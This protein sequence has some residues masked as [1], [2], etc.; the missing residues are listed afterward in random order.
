M[1]KTAPI[2]QVKH[3]QTTFSTPHGTTK[4]VDNIS[5]EVYPGETVAIV[6]ESGSGKSVTALS[7]MRLL[8]TPPAKIAAGEAIFQS[9]KLGQVDL[10]ALPEKQMQQVRG[11]EISMIFQEPMSSLNPVFTCGKQ[12]AEVLLLHKNVSR[13]E[14]KERT[15]ALFE[16]AKLPNPEKIYAAYP[17]QISGGQKQRVMIAMAMACKPSL[18]MA[19]EPTTALDVTVQARILQLMDELRVKE[20]T[21]V[22]FISHDF[23]VVAEVADRV[24]VMYKGKIVEQGKVLDIFTNPQHPYT[25]GLLACRPKMSFKPQYILPTVSDFMEE[26]AFGNIIKQT[27]EVREPLLVG[28]VSNHEN[29]VT[30]LKQQQEKRLQPPLLQVEN[31]KVYFPLRKGFFSRTID[32]TKAVDGV[33]FEI[34]TGE[35]VALVGESGCGKTTLGRV[36]IRLIEPTEGNI[37]FEGRDLTKLQ[38][39][40]LRKSRRDFQIVFQD[41]YA[42]LNPMHTI[43]EAVMEPMHVHKLYASTKERRGKAMELL[44]K[45]GLLPEHFDR[46]PHEFSGGQRQ[47]ISIARALALQPKFIICDEAVSSLDVSVQAQVL[48]LLNQLKQEFQMTYLFITHDLSV[49]RYMADSIL[50]MN[51]GQIVESDTPD[52]IFQNPQQEYTRTLISAIPK[53]EPAD[54]MAAQERRQAMRVN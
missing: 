37:L 54:I 5:F 25:K 29:M 3:L 20:N 22:L 18:L 47:R 45:V 34:K 11:N 4:A 26:D 12:V 8:H 38:A 32:Y 7:L 41:P 30:D 24:L 9:Q 42:S 51:K 19:D 36:L 40:D 10:L 43:G 31:L 33:S 35:T 48:N 53:G 49:A 13:K 23:G 44:E 1:P 27:R 46:Y 52:Q 14:G 39:E 50:V 17:H 6:G 2:L 21:A 16:Q 28:V 15:I